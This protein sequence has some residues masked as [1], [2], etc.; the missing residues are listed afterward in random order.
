[1]FPGDLDFS[2]GKFWQQPY[3]YVIFAVER[4]HELRRQELHLQELP[5]A[6]VSSILANQNRDPRKRRKPFSAAD[7]CYFIPKTNEDLPKGRFGAAAM[8]MIKDGRFPSW[9]LFCYSELSSSATKGYEPEE[10]ALIAEDAILLHPVKEENRYSGMLIAMESASA[11]TREFSFYDGSKVLLKLPEI[12]NK[13]IAEEDVSL[14]L[15]AKT[16]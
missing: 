9:A 8:K 5:T 3:H 12:P 6:Q 14:S 2:L 1:M 16:P 4:A 7:F 11:Q 10:P 13:I 15:Q